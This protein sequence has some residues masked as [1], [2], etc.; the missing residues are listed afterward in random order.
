MG[1]ATSKIASFIINN[2]GDD[3]GDIQKNLIYQAFKLAI[4]QIT[5]ESK[6]I[7][8]QEILLK[9]LVKDLDYKF[10]VGV[11]LDAFGKKRKNKK[12]NNKRSRRAF[13]KI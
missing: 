9:I 3:N 2:I 12:K 5:D 6:R 4:N 13:K 11:G 7:R 8:L 10:G 1:L